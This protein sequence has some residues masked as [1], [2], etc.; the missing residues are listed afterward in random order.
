MEFFLAG[1]LF[2]GMS[3]IKAKLARS[4][5]TPKERGSCDRR[6]E[7]CRKEETLLPTPVRDGVYL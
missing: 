6:Y 4:E 7:T 2:Q 1:L 3:N 5:E